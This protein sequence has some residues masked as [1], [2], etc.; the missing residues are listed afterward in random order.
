MNDGSNNVEDLMHTP[1]FESTPTIYYGSTTGASYDNTYC[2]PYQVTW[3]VDPQVQLNLCL[4]LRR[5][6]P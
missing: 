4:V 5:H 3:A 1:G 6:V 2:S